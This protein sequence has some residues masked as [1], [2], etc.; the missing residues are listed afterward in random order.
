ME[1]WK[2]V[3]VC[4]LKQVLL[5]PW[6]Q[7]IRNI[8]D[9]DDHHVLAEFAACK[10]MA[11]DIPLETSVSS[12]WLLSSKK[13]FTAEP[14]GTMVL[15]CDNKQHWCREKC[16]PIH[17]CQCTSQ[18]LSMNNLASQVIIA[19][20]SKTDCMSRCWVFNCMTWVAWAQP[21]KFVFY[22]LFFCDKWRQINYILLELVSM[23]LA[24]IST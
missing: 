15:V 3:R 19:K 16:Q 24:D 12:F 14:A 5:L 2:S 18:Q 7:L 13:I 1:F 11:T 10:A 22:T 20:H 9:A 21:F 17:N 23:L 4:D 6:D 8:Q